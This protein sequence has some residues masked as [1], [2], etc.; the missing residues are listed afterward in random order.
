L[1]I[2]QGY[3]G[4]LALALGKY[5]SDRASFFVFRRNLRAFAE[6]P[7]QASIT[8][9]FCKQFLLFFDLDGSISSIWTGFT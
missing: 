8:I 4:R 9:M 2:K 7:I 1:C 5:P 3:Y 6:I